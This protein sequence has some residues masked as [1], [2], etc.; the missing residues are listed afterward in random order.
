MQV[1]SRKH[2]RG[3][4][5]M[6]YV[7]SSSNTIYD[8]ADFQTSDPY[9]D[10][11]GG[12]TTYGVDF[13]FRTTGYIDVFYNVDTPDPGN[14]QDPYTN[15]TDKC[16]VRVTHLLGDTF[17]ELTGDALGSWHL[18]STQRRFLFEHTS[19]G[20]NDILAGTY[21]F[22]LS[23]DSSGSPVEASEDVQISAGEVI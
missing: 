21:R 11:G 20:G 18:C 5:I 4:I 6:G 14:V 15:R 3:S 7:A 17:T 1:K 10:L 22:E 12:T 16:W 19:G 2:Q 8:L 23:S 13:I 9:Q